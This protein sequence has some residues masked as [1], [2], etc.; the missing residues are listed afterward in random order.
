MPYAPPSP[1]CPPLPCP[2]GHETER[3]WPRFSVTIV[4]EKRATKEE[5]RFGI[6]IKVFRQHDFVLWITADNHK[7]VAFLNLLQV[8]NTDTTPGSEQQN[9]EK[10]KKT[11]E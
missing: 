1:E 10:V 2:S 6:G 11:Q 3:T 5:L 9:L 8:E 4:R 7:Q